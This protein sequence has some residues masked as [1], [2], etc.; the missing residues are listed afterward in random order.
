MAGTV[1]GRDG[2]G[3]GGGIFMRYD[4]YCCDYVNVL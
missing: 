1:V 3:G 2:G 4:V